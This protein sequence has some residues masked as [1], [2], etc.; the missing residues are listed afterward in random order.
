MDD[1][2]KCSQPCQ[3][4]NE[5][6]PVYFLLEYILLPFFFI[7]LFTR[8]LYVDGNNLQCEGILDLVC[9]TADFEHNEAVV[10]EEDCIDNK[11]QDRFIGKSYY[12]T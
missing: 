9:I 5:L 2:I 1:I 6:L 7:S 12:T 3:T 8:E 4:Y 11:E 10:R